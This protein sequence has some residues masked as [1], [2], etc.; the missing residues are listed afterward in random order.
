MVSPCA[1][2]MDGMCPELDSGSP[3]VQL[4]LRTSICSHSF[5]SHDMPALE[6]S[7]L[8]TPA[9]KKAKP[10]QGSSP[11]ST[12][13]SKMF[14]KFFWAMPLRDVSCDFAISSNSCG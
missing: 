5:K 9:Y 12:T 10:V 14:M 13:F 1:V 7:H 3:D 2:G 4:E 11:F 6:K 8:P